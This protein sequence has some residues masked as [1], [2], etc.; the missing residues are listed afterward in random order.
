MSSIRKTIPIAVAFALGS[1]LSGAVVWADSSHMRSALDHLK[2]ARLE[3]E[4]ATHD[5]GG[6][7]VKALDA[8]NSAIEQVKLAEKDAPANAE[9]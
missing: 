5:R 8:V 1:L 7:R 9:K 4:Q 6:H 3:L 2:S